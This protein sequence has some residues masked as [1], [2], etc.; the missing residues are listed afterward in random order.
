MKRGGHCHPSAKRGHWLA[1]DADNLQMIALPS[2]IVVVNA[3]VGGLTWYLK[4]EQKGRGHQHMHAI[5]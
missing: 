2:A 5:E 4:R 3:V 1:I